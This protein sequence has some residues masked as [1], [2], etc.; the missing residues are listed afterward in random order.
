[1]IVVTRNQQIPDGGRAHLDQ[2]RVFSGWGMPVLG[3]ERAE[4]SAVCY[5]HKR[6]RLG[7]TD[8][9]DQVE[10]LSGL[11]DSFSAHPPKNTLYQSQ[12]TTTLLAEVGFDVLKEIS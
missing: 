9:L 3:I 1:M 6:T 10:N 12:E 5:S 11:R 4:V 8:A 2:A 7:P